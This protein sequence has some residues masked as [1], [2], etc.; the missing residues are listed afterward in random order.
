MNGEDK[1]VWAAN[2]GGISQHS[3]GILPLELVQET[4][5]SPQ[6]SNLGL[7]GSQ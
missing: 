1:L 6:A 4:P 7:K 3:K 5:S 2:I